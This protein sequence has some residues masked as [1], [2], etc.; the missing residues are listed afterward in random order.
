MFARHKEKDNFHVRLQIYVLEQAFGP[1]MAG[2]TYR[3]EP[4]R[5]NDISSQ[6]NSAG[7]RR[8]GGSTSVGNCNRVPLE[9]EPDDYNSGVDEEKLYSDVIRNLRRPPRAENQDG[10]HN[11]V[12]VDDDAVGEDEDLAAVEWDP[13]NPH[14]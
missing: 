13:L 12:C 6:N 8:R 14:M 10:A 4:S 3:G 5:R 1:R 2:A 11:A 7:A 9:V